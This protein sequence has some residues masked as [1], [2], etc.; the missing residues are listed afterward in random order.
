MSLTGCALIHFS[1]HHC[2]LQFKCGAVVSSL[3]KSIAGKDLQ[4]REISPR[5]RT[6]VQNAD[7]RVR[8]LGF[9]RGPRKN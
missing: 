7:I 9:E 2:A 1:A 8:Y 4:S 3:K 6:L 5:N